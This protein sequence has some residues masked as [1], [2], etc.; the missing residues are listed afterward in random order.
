MREYERRVCAHLASLSPRL[1]QE[2]L[3]AI[4]RPTERK[5]CMFSSGIALFFSLFSLLTDELEGLLE[6]LPQVLLV[7]VGGGQPLV[8]EEAGV[9][10]VERQVR[11]HVEDVADVVALQQVQVLSVVLVPQ[12]EEGQDGRQL[13]VLD[14]WGGGQGVR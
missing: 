2:Q 7:A 12:V 11:G 8:D 3:A 14:V 13:G 9:V 1:G 10:V 5:A 6:V 4:N